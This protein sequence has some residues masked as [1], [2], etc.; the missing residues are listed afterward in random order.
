MI[1]A[2]IFD[3]DGLMFDTESMFLKGFKQVCADGGIYITEEFVS[4]LIGCDSDTVKKFE[5]QYP[6]IGAR[7][8]VFQKERLNIFMK[9]YPNPEDGCKPGLKELVHYLNEKKIP[10]AIASSSFKKD[11]ERLIEYANCDIHPQEIVSSKE[12]GMPSKP[13]P[14]IF[15]EAAKRLGKDPE[16]CLVLEDSKHGIMAGRR[17]GCK[18]IFIP[19]Q[20]E[21]DRQMYPYI[22]WKMSSLHDVIDY[23][24]KDMI[25]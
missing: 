23:L 8:D 11:I 22:Q 10:Y 20:I 24:E 9:M 3:M 13:D 18:T 6:G 25:K 19:D 2:V 5:E 14:T 12:A 4:H 21:Q 17:A 7:M 16:N 1:E 15:K